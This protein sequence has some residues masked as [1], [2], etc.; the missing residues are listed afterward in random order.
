MDD[1]Q[2][3]EALWA[4]SIIHEKSME[5]F[6]ALFTEHYENVENY[7]CSIGL[8]AEYAEMIRNKLLSSEVIY[9]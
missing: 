6:I 9:E 8:S 1:K 4:Y 2:R 3:A 7:F 5:R